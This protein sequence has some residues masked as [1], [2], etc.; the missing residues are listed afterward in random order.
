MQN[1]NKRSNNLWWGL[2]LIAAGVIFLLQNMGFY[3]NLG[4]LVAVFLFSAGGLI[5]LFTFLT[6]FRE[7]WWAAIPGTTLLG[8]A[9]TVL[10]D[11]YAPAFL[12][13][14][15]GPFFLASIGI[16][17]ALVYLSDL[18]KWWALIPGGV[19]VTLGTVAAVDELRFLRIDS[20]GIFF[21]GLG[22]T[23]LAVALL[24]GQRGERQSWALIPAAVLTL[25]GIFIGT[26]WLGTLANLWPVAL[27]VVGIIWVVRASAQRD[28]QITSQDRPV[29][30]STIDDAESDR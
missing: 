25:M 15:G 19:M 29:V 23:F 7:R 22:V 20:G 30:P 10:F 14:L 12:A 18:N 27:I 8:L 3:L 17:F 26:P 24:T 11:N 16:G 1:I 6:N 9:A 2:L 28:K 13:G 4:P 5:F 21:V